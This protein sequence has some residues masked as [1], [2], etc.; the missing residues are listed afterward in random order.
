MTYSVAQH[1]REVWTDY[2]TRIQTYMTGEFPDD[3][4]GN[5]YNSPYERHRQQMAYEQ[6]LDWLEGAMPHRIQ[7]CPTVDELIAKAKLTHCYADARESGYANPGGDAASSDSSDDLPQGQGH[8]NAL[9]DEE[10]PPREL[11][12]TKARSAPPPQAHAHRGGKR[13]RSD[14]FAWHDHHVLSVDSDDEGREVDLKRYFKKHRVSAKQQVLLCRS[15]ASY[16]NA[17]VT[18]RKRPALDDSE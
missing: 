10:S 13:P 2:Y 3:Y 15:Y 9:L 1:H 8:L 4:T 18:A 12:R 17:K 7:Q 16:V 6:W 14:M 5:F 11:V